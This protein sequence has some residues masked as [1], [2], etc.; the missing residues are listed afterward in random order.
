MKFF[1]WKIFIL[2]GIVCLSPILFGVAIWD[3]LPETIAIH[4]NFYGEPDGYAS[5]GFAVFGLPVMMVLIQ[6]FCCF[7]NDKNHKETKNV[8]NIMKWIIPC[9]TFVL[10]I[11]TLGYSLG[12]DIDIT[13]IV[14]ILFL[15][16]G[17][18][19]PKLDYAK[20]YNTDTEKAKKLTVLQAMQQL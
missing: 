19:I 12:Q 13:L 20:T 7:L 15:V 10:Y 17:K 2:T 8:E 1:K 3:K 5:K 18:Y 9:I 4:F 14:G 6:A 16:I 11:I